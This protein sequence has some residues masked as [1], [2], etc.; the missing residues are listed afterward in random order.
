MNNYTY[1]AD[2][3]LWGPEKWES[4]E[5]NYNNKMVYIPKSKL[6]AQETSGGEFITKNNKQDYM[7]PYIE[8]SEGKYYAGNDVKYLGAELIK[9]FKI[10]TKFGGGEDFNRYLKLRIEPYRTLSI[11]RRRLQKR[12]V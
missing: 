10:S 6:K 3:H 8:T 12:M 2:E 11:T 1:I 7:G 4:L 9:P 5:L